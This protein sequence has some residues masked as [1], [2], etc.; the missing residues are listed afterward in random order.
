MEVSLYLNQNI[1]NTFFCF[2]L[3]LLS[4]KNLVGAVPF[5]YT[6]EG[7]MPLISDP[8]PP[9]PPPTN[10]EKNKFHPPPPEFTSINTPLPPEK[11]YQ[12]HNFLYRNT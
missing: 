4:Y 9:P 3:I 8:P 1:N 10:R 11:N 5:K 6:W 12:K 7:G 2:F